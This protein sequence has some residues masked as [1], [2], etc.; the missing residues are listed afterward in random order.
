MTATDT[1]PNDVRAGRASLMVLLVVIGTTLLVDVLARDD[2]L[3]AWI[4]GRWVEK[5]T[6]SFS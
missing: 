4:H 6:V 3:A 5:W 2:G 1:L